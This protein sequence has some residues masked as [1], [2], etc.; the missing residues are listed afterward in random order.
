MISGIVYYWLYHIRNLSGLYI[1]NREAQPKKASYSLI[2]DYFSIL[3]LCFAFK[4]AHGPRSQCYWP[5]SMYRST[6][7]FQTRS[8]FS[9]LSIVVLNCY[10]YVFRCLPAASDYFCCWFQ[11]FTS[12]HEIRNEHYCSFQNWLK[13]QFEGTICGTS[14]LLFG[15]QSRIHTTV[16]SC[17]I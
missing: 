13:G 6:E 1:F 16:S 7:I 9:F 8:R 12:L 10:C 3:Y 5:E 17:F 11:F 4:F 14:I 15:R 2:I